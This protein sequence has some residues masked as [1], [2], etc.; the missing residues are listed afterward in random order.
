MALSEELYKRLIDRSEGVTPFL[1]CYSLMWAKIDLTV[2]GPRQNRPGGFSPQDRGLARVR[3]GF[4]F[5]T[6][7]KSFPPSTP[8]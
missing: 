8:F 7:R 1:F 2:S 3:K 6:Q 5:L 4:Y